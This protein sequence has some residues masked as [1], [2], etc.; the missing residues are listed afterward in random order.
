MM[1]LDPKSV[2]RCAI[3]TRKSSE[4]GLEQS[5]NSLDAQREACEAFIISQRQ[6]GWRALAA[7]Y[8]DGGFSGG[9]MD[10]PALKRL[11]EDVEAHKVDTIVVY[12]VDRLTRSLADFAKIVE[13]FDA[14]GVS[15]VSVTQQFNTTSSMG[16]L[17]LNVLLSFAQFER[18]VTGERIRDKIAASKKKGMWMGGTIPLGY[19]VKE[20]KLIVN[21]EEA[22]FVRRLFNLY[23]ELGSVSQVKLRLDKEKIRTKIRVSA[24]GKRSGG[25][26]YSRGGLYKLLENKLY[27][28]EIH[29]RGQCHQGEHEAI[30]PRDLWEKVQ[31]QLQ[32]D[33]QGGRIGLRTNSPSLLVGLVQDSSGRRFIPSHTV[34]NGKRYRY[35]VCQRT[36]DEPQKSQKPIRIAAQELE[37]LVC[38]RLQSFL[39]S[40][41]D[42]L[43]A[44]SLES[45]T[46]VQPQ[47]IL[48]RA[49]ELSKH[50]LS[51]R[52]EERSFV[53]KLIRQV[54]V[55]SNKIVV[56]L[57]RNHLNTVLASEAS[58]VL[59]GAGLIEDSSDPISD[60]K[61]LQNDAVQLEVEARI[62]RCGLE[63][64]LV[65]APK[66]TALTDRQ[67][68]PSLLKAVARG[69]QWA[70]WIRAGEVSGQRPLARRLGMTKRYVARVLECAYLAPDI[71]EAILDG[72]QPANLSFDTLT[73]RLP[74][75]WSS[76]RQILGFK[77]L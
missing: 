18:E 63:M 70:E 27:L 6:E 35:Y 49:F 19:D 38:L 26:T 54:V 33:N 28:G 3:Y 46:S 21:P 36:N 66:H 59:D 4:E 16:R 12:K 71:V 48:E 65:V 68:V 75:D 30:V 64:R 31:K 11:L 2:V 60:D 40:P 52:S 41:R 56:Q 67:T 34:K 29:H 62:T 58:G 39:K 20:R 17:T 15:F 74:M 42:L 43:D 45:E 47:Q 76:Q 73:R 44:L 25:T 9:N 72:R 14:R 5:F 53:R 23:L 50:C 10:R 32:S 1:S 55:N 22:K 37:K 69:H 57:S 7:H 24:S 13:A 8:D 51:L 61:G 77:N